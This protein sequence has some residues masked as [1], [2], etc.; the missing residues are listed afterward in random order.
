[1][2]KNTPGKFIFALILFF[3]LIGFRFYL[4]EPYIKTV[5]PGIESMFDLSVNM[6]SV[7]FGE[8]RKTMAAMLWGRLMI[9]HTE[10]SH[11]SLPK[12]NQTGPRINENPYI[13]E[14]TQLLPILRLITW[15]DPN[16]IKAY[17]FGGYFLAINL[18]K[19]KD[20]IAFLQEGISNNPGNYDLN[21]G[22]AFI[23]FRKVENYELAI[24]YGKQSLLAA[25]KLPDDDINKIANCANSL[26]LIGHSYRKSGNM[27]YAHKYFL[28]I[29][30]V[31]PAEAGNVKHLLELKQE[32]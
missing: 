25:I 23:Y 21:F 9:Y 24:K 17:D 20:G 29:E 3:C 14:G 5:N 13:K 26:R 12:K 27:E 11:A 28:M 7:L 4:D 8:T 2:R 6:A 31:N 1:M 32:D 18:N 19:S 22:L 15:L 30:E 10:T 16:F